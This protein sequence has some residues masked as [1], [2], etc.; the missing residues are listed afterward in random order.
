MATTGVYNRV[1]LRTSSR[2]IGEDG[3]KPNPNSN[4]NATLNL[5]LTLSLTLRKETK[6]KK[7]NLLVELLNSK[8]NRSAYDKPSNCARWQFVANYVISLPFIAKHM[9]DKKLFLSLTRLSFPLVR[10]RHNRI[11]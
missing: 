2:T 4:P 7:E 11:T 10:F 3:S 1:R 6:T 8:T 5:T 9:I